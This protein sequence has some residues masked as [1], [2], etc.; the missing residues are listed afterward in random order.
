MYP[1]YEFY[2]GRKVKY[3]VSGMAKNYSGLN[4][5]LSEPEHVLGS[6]YWFYVRRNKGKIVVRTP[7]VEALM[8]G[9]KIIWKREGK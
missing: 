2:P 8:D 1:I 6:V 7:D 3:C 9:K 4:V 5:I